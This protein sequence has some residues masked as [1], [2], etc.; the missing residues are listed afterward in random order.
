M[1]ELDRPNT[2]YKQRTTIFGVR[3]IGAEIGLNLA[4]W[5]YYGNF[6]SELDN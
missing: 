5:F 2:F 3:K 4:S 6:C 1:V